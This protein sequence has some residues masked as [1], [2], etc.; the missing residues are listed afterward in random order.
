M[1]DLDQLRGPVS[2]TVELPLWLFWSGAGAEAGRFRVDIP[3][4]QRVLYVTVLREAGS[5]ADLSDFVSGNLLV[6]S[7]PGVSVRLP[8]TVRAAWEQQH[9]SLR[10]T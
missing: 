1:A 4:E 2:G 7:W 5:S 9:V 10:Q 6:A 8:K 3:I